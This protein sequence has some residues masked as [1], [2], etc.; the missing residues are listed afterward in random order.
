MTRITRS[1]KFIK[2][3]FQTVCAETGK[4]IAK[5]A[6]CLYLPESKQVFSLDSAEAAEFRKRSLKGGNV[7]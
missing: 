2:S 3:K 4:P 7:H 5:G 6:G 1:A